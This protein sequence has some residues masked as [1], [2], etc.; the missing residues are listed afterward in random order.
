MKEIMRAVHCGLVCCKF[1]DHV[2]VVFETDDDVV[3]H[4]YTKAQ[5]IEKCLPEE[6][7]RLLI[8]FSLIQESTPPVFGDNNLIDFRSHRTNATKGPYTI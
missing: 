6:G 2:I 3:E 5:F 1:D 4:V 8:Q 7:T